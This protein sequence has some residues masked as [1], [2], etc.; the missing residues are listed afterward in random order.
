LGDIHVGAD[1]RKDE[2]PSDGP[3]L[4]HPPGLDVAHIELAHV[5]HHQPDASLLHWRDGLVTLR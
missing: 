3:C 1:G 4:N 2:G 5:V